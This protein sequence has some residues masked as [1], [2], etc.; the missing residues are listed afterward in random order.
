MTALM[1]QEA[2]Q[3]LPPIG[4][5]SKNTSVPRGQSLRIFI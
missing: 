2:D 1:R 3:K 5:M 4:S